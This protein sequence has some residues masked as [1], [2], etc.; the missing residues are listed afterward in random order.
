MSFQGINFAA[1]R[2]VPSDDG[3]LYSAIFND[4]ATE[5]CNLSYTG[6]NLT[7]S[8]GYIIAGGRQMEVESPETYN[9]NQAVSGYAQLVLRIDLTKT[10]TLS[11]FNQIDVEVRYA[12]AVDGFASLL[13]EDINGN[14]SIYEM[15]LAVVS[16]GA[17]GITGIVTDMPQAKLKG[18]G[19]NLNFRVLGD[20]SQ[21][22]SPK[23]N[24]IWINTNTAIHHY[25]F[26]A[27]QPYLVS[28]NKNLI[29]YPYYHT[30]KTENGITWTDN[31][32]GTVK[33]NGTSSAISKFRCSYMSAQDKE[34]MLEPGTYVLSG[35]PQGGRIFC[36]YSYDNWATDKTPLASNG[37]TA[38]ITL[39]KPARVRINIEISA[40]ETVSNIVF[41]PQ[42]EKGSTA[43]SFVKG[44]A[45]GQVWFQT[46]TSAPAA[47]NALKKNN[48]TVYPISCKQYVSGAWTSK[49]AKTYQSG[50]WKDWW[51]GELFVGGKTSD[52]AGGW[53]GWKIPYDSAYTSEAQ[54]ASV[55]V[56]STAITASLTAGG[57]VSG[58]FRSKKMIDV[59][60]FKTLKFVVTSSASQTSIG[61]QV[62][63]LPSNAKSAA[64]AVAI[65]KVT[66]GA[67]AT[68]TLDITNISGSYYVAV[69]L[70]SYTNTCNITITEISMSR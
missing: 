22:A 1:Q 51:N 8:T 60:N 67:S 21:P 24:D 16:L 26:S 34:M 27:E 18:G 12:A 39:T 70:A 68:Y 44:D 35:A 17:G 53:E 48:I 25:D 45:S 23:E 36:V 42:L 61:N 3:R 64:D 58:A 40:G 32:D 11:V 2:L 52:Q 62:C 6:S 69:I 33:A 13:Q 20:T 4:G 19:A 31:G 15:Q 7:I 37:G 9:I 14:G 56:S 38:E 47:F 28:K 59:T 10:A 30:T 29:T 43:T 55:S 50:A 54:A 63:L 5:G 57:G 49:T 65:K 41:K 66:A 46:G